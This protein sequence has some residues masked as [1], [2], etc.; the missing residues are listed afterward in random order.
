MT[1]QTFERKTFTINRALEF[2]SEKELT[3]Q[4]G[5]PRHMWPIA[6]VKELID[7]ALD[8]CEG[9]AAGAPEIMVT[10]ESD[11]VTVADNGPGLPL[12]TLQRS[13]DYLVRVSDK[14]HYVSPT[15]GQLGNALKCVWAAPFV[16]SGGEHGRVVVS[17]HG[18]THTIDV[19]LDHIAG[20]PSI[21]LGSEPCDVKTGTIIKMGWP[22]IA[23]YLSGDKIP[24]FY[25]AP[26]V[27]DLAARYAA[28]NPDLT[29]TV[30]DAAEGRQD[31]WARSATEAPR[32]APNRP[33]SPHWYTPE[34][35]RT[36]LA[37]ELAA[38]RELAAAPTV[39]EFVAKF[40]GLSSSA[41]QKA[42]TD[43]AGL[44]NAPLSALIAG[45]EIDQEKAA[46]LL[47]G[48][49]EQSRPIKPAALGAIGKAHLTHHLVT[50]CFVEA[51]SI[52]YRKFEEE[53]D[54]M[55]AI[56]ELAFGIYVKELQERSAT[57]AVGANW[58]PVLT[59][60]QITPLQQALTKARVDPGDPIALIVHLTSP[61]IET[62]DKGK[63]A[64]IL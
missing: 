58:S 47:R 8:A 13:L 32:W 18:H 46:V 54:G 40:A 20:Q 59:P 19:S 61:R 28:F 38:A 49:R 12:A 37:G 3:M 10:V 53:A 36:L 24:P 44:T 31:T 1:L 7:N 29:I 35:F 22:G 64:I 62:T 21:T 17:A 33:T 41:R 39:R 23:G 15:R 34:R 27:W 55:P 26:T 6:L 2:F 16:V 42:V 51:E 5:H 43:A 9:G 25:K 11:E 4:I 48:M 63:G 50:D 60:S 30:S 45:N 14:A 52:Q 56:L 57:I